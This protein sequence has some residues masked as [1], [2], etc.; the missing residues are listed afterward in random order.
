MVIADDN[1]LEG[2]EVF[3]IQLQSSEPFFL[4][5]N[6]TQAS[7]TIYPDPADCKITLCLKV[8]RYLNLCA[9]C[10]TIIIHMQ[11]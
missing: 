5:S 4:G 3:L 2:S 10:N 7:V 6:L 9:S 8:L 11:L 1:I